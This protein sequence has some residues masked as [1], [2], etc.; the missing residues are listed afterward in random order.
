MNTSYS[1]RTYYSTYSNGGN[2]ICNTYY[3]QVSQSGFDSYLKAFLISVSLYLFLS[4][5]PSLINHLYTSWLHHNFT[6]Q[7]NYIQNSIKLYGSL[8]IPLL[9]MINAWE[10]IKLYVWKDMWDLFVFRH[11]CTVV[12]KQT[13]KSRFLT[14]RRTANAE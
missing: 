13:A 2:F 11:V 8:I 1:S 10:K 7:C 5:L 14:D 9:E 3:I 12:N 6:L 4:A